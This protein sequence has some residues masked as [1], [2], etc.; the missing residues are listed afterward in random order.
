MESKFKKDVRSE[1]IIKIKNNPFFS[2]IFKRK[3]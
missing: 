1:R 2:K 3:L